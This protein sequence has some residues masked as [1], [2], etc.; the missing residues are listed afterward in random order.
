MKALKRDKFTVEI[1]NRILKFDEK[2]SQVLELEDKIL[3]L[4]NKYGHPENDPDYGRN[5]VAFDARGEELWRIEDSGVKV[6]GRTMEKVSQGY[7]GLRETRDGTIHAWAMDWRHDLD[8]KT[9]K[10]SNPKYVR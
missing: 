2:I 4:L 3:I 7:T 1:G 8:P 6:R 9:G 5:V 10:I